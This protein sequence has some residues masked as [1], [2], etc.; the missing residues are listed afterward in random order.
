[1]KADPALNV[2]RVE[3]LELDP[4]SR[5]VH[6]G[7]H[8]IK[9]SPKEFELLLLLM[10]QAGETVTRHDLLRGSWGLQPESDSN[11]V[12]VYVN[13]LRRKI[14]FTDEDKLIHTIRGAGYRIGRPA[15]PHAESSLSEMQSDPAHIDLNHNFQHGALAEATD[16]LSTQQQSLRPLIQSLAH[17]LAQPLTSVR[18]F[19]EVT[20]MHKSGSQLFLSDLRTVEQQ[21]DRA[22]TLAKAISILVREV[23]APG[24]PWTSL[25]SLLNDLFTDFVVLLNSGLLTLERQWS[26]A[27]QVTS[28]P[29]LRHLMVLFLS[30]L[31]GRNTR[32]MVLT[33]SAQANDGRCV[34]QLKWQPAD[35]AQT[36]L[37]DGKGIIAKELAYIQELVYSIGGELSLTDGH[38]EIVLKVPAATHH[39]PRPD[40]VVH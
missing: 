2:L 20:G 29:V 25:D 36:P 37:L 35:A 1:R 38:S 17:D 4:V 27:I 5:K 7:K 8:E 14:D 3:D 10:R 16:A 23:P 19:L 13:Y 24:A 30:K 28:S 6:R 22:I 11:L 12:D 26:P 34:I 40:T 21:T 32:P 15:P 18:C 9:L 31:I 39:P 33:I